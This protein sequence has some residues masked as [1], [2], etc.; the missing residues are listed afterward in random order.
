[1]LTTVMANPKQVITTRCH[2]AMHKVEIYTRTWCGYCHMAKSLLQSLGC[3]FQE[4]D[5][6]ADA[7]LQLE[8]FQRTG[9]RTVPQVL[10]NDHPLG[11]FTD[12]ARLQRKG[13]LARMLVGADAD[14]ETPGKL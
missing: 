13:V 5:I 9:H 14:P 6:E 11:G 8:M 2:R 7:G 12:L 10:I 4:Y 1:M 3:Q